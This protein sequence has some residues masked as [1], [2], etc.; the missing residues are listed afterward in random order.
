MRF[1]VFLGRGGS[2]LGRPRLQESGRLA[3]NIGLQVQIQKDNAEAACNAQ[4]EKTASC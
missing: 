2:K 3:Q 4:E 1:V